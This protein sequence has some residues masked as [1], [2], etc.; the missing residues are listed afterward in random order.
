M[1][2]RQLKVITLT[3][4]NPNGTGSAN[5]STINDGTGA[6]GRISQTYVDSVT[7]FTITILPREGGIAYPTGA[8]ATLTFNVSTS[9]K[10]N[11]NIP[12]YAIPGVSLVV[13]NTL[14]TAI[15]D[16]A[17]VETFY[18]GGKEPTIGQTYYI[19]FTRDRSS[20]NTRTFTN[21]ADVVRTYGEISLENTLSM[22]A[23]LAFSNGATALACKQIQLD[24]GVVQPSEDQM[25]TALQE[26]EGEIVPGLSPSVIVPLMPA[27]TALLSAISNHC[28]VQSS[29]RYRSERRAVL[30]CAVGTQPR[31]A[32][33]LAQATGNSRVCLIYPDIANIRFTDSQGVAQSYFVGGEMIAVAV[34]MAT[35]NPA[36][37]S[38][39]PWTNRSVNGFTDL[40]RILDDVDANTTAN[41]GITVLKQTPQGI[42]VRHGLTTNM[43]SVLTKTPTVVQIADDV[44]LRVRNLCN[45]YIGTKFVP[46]T[47]SQ[48]EGRVNALFKQLVRDQIISTYT[49][50]TVATDP[51]DPT[52]LLVDVFYKPVYPLLYI[53]FTFT[54][55][56]S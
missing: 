43:T 35:S 13:S 2:K 52:G 47:I 26:I 3:S 4:N 10:T 55:Q 30:G 27:S 46:N 34:A 42:Q 38:A 7:G 36:I 5:T 53:Q 39:T 45:R 8:D 24:T 56:G 11:A 54:V 25:V 22:G 28:D 41:A 9:I 16:N 44:H 15:G 18:K 48:I 14:D 32:Q 31:D 21:L 29:L 17:L 33:A 40:G 51:N 49:G 19:D 37:D 20:F 12:Q 23:F 1:E 6:D 50:L